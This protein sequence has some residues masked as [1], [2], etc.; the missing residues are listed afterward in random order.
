MKAITH[1]DFKP[2]DEVERIRP[3]A[4]H[5]NTK[6][7]KNRG[8]IISIYLA[9]VSGVLVR[10]DHGSKNHSTYSLSDWKKTK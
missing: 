9:P 10:I 2:G 5:H 3:I 1:P 6:Y 8:R 7:N 4:S